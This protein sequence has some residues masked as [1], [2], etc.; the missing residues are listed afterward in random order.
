[1]PR[2]MHATALP[3]L[4]GKFTYESGACYE[5]QWEAGV[6]Q[7]HGKFTWPDG[8]RWVW[9]ANVLKHQVIALL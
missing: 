7:G 4:Q 1:M 3:R 6:Y 5:G 9:L 8:R 2:L